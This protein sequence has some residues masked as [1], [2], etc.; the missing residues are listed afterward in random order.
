MNMKRIL[1]LLLCLS[2]FTTF[3]GCKADKTDEVPQESEA[4]RVEISVSELSEYVII[5]SSD[6]AGESLNNAVKDLADT[7]NAQFNVNI[8][9]RDDLIKKSSGFLERDTEIIIGETNRL[10]GKETLSEIK[11]ANDYLIKIKDKKLIVG[12][13][14]PEATENAVEKLISILS[15]RSDKFFDSEDNVFVSG[16]YDLDNLTVDGTSISEFK[17]IFQSDPEYKRTAELIRDFICQSTGYMLD[18]VAAGK[19]A[20][21][22]NNIL[23]GNVGASAPERIDGENEYWLGSKNGSIYVYALT[24]P[25]LYEAATSLC[26]A[27]SSSNGVLELSN[28]KHIASSANISTMSFNVYWDTS[29]QTRVN[30]VLSTIEKYSPDTF[31]VQEATPQ[32]I[33]LLAQKFGDEYA[34]VGQGR[35]S[36]GEYNAIFYKKNKFTLVESGTKWMSGTPDVSGSK[37]DGSIYPRIFTYALLKIKNTDKQFIHVNTHPDHT[38]NKTVRLEQVKVLTS[39]LS[40]KYKNIPTVLTGDFNDT[41]EAPSIQHILSSGFENSMQNAFVT[42]SS[43]TFKQSVIDYAFISPNDFFVYEYDV[44]TDTYNGSYPSDH[45]PVIVRYKVL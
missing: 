6:D 16:E 2:L 4:E 28:G 22:G 29:D 5:Y 10:D 17:I 32:W 44:V 3:F 11:K 38:D 45:R 25:T 9:I 20:P 15:Q 24:S 34:Y 33:T 40:S 36:G 23:V 1:S 8:E 7:I 27:I 41:S 37:L 21:D 43:H 13:I 26:N 18:I 30:N 19:N 12:G 35:T 31:G 14:T 39:F 42:E